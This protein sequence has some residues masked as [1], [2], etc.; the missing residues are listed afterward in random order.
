[1]GPDHAVRWQRW[2][3]GP[4][5][6]NGREKALE[7]LRRGWPAGDEPRYDPDHALVLCRLAAYRPG[8]VL[9]YENMR[10]FREVLRVRPRSPARPQAGQIE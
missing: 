8:L 2:A 1:L 6:R 7:L 3:R 10:L 4:A 5:R 9:L